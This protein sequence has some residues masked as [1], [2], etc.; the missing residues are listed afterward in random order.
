MRQFIEQKSELINNL[1][2]YSPFYGMIA[3]TKSY[4]FT[5]IILAV[6]PLELPFWPA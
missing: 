3:R 6:F 2:T 5:E 1:L 4:A